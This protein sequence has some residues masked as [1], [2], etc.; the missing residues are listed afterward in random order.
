LVGADAPAD[1]RLID[2][3][4][5]GSLATWYLRHFTCTASRLCDPAADEALEA[6]RLAPTAAERHTQLATADQLLSALT[7]FIPIAAPIRWSMVSPR[8]NGFRPNAFVHHPAG[9]LIAQE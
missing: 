4:A 3:V 2:S 6:A 8:I 1:L 7:P 5:P 9:T